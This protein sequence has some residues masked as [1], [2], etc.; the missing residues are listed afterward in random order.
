MNNE[1]KQRFTQACYKYLDAYEQLHG[2]SN[3]ASIV[4]MAIE[5]AQLHS[6]N[7]GK[8]QLIRQSARRV[9]L[10]IRIGGQWRGMSK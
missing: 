5:R 8:K 4:D 10:D 1:S 3:Y 9:Q 7:G 6:A 2:L